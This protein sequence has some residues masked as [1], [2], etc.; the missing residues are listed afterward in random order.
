MAKL[1]GADKKTVL[2]SDLKLADRYFLRLKG[3]LGTKTL[4]ND[5]GLWIDQ[6][7]SIHTFFM[8]Y[9]IDCVFLNSKFEVQSIVK[10]VRP[11]RMVWP[12]SG[13]RS[14]VEMAAG[15]SESLNLKKGDQLH[16]G[17]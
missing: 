4:G 3:L 9:S 16:V 6:C 2:L 17:N 11:G 15:R 10:N 14:V 8:N 7:N 5:Q 1:L 12:Q 13:A